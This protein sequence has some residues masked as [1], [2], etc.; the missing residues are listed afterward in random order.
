MTFNNLVL[1]I[2]NAAFEKNIDS[3]KINSTA[4]SCKI[5]TFN[6]LAFFK[7]YA[8]QNWQWTFGDGTAAVGQNISHTFNGEGSFNVK[9]VITDINGCTE[10]VTKSISVAACATTIINTYTPIV[11]LST[12]DNKITVEDDSTF[13]TG[14]TVLIIQMKGADIDSSNT[15]SFG[16]VTN[17]KNAGNYEFNYVK[18][19]AGNVIELK[20]SLTRGYDIPFGK[21][22]LI[23]IPY[24]KSLSATDILTCLPWDGNK[25]GVLVLNVKDTLTL[26]A[27]VDVS[28]KGFNGGKAINSQSLIWQPGCGT[29]SYYS[30]STNTAE[31]GKGEG[32][33]RIN[34]D[35]SSGR[36]PLANGGG[37]GNFTNSGGGG[38]SNGY[39]AGKGGD[40]YQECTTTPSNNG[41]LAGKALAY[42]SAVNKIFMGGG[43]GAGYANDPNGTNS[44]NPDGGNG[45]GRYRNCTVKLS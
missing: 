25:G 21:V 22:Q 2:T 7:S 6:G 15:A 35:K 12:C 3:V 17:Y 13:N 26:N 39:T 9:L 14:D 30:V 5:F 18:S 43:G 24:F 34:L 16:T 41:G 27:P 8:T 36:G 45:G 44:F 10:S 42:S 28:V 19:K 33:S 40:Q 38:G 32:I 23:R 4:G 29:N 20:D 37:G 1:P 31:Q 11:A